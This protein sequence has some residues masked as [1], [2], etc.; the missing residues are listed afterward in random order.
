VEVKRFVTGGNAITDVALGLDGAL[1][2]ASLGEGTVH[3]VAF[4]NPTDLIVTPT[5]FQMIEG[6]T[7]RFC[8]RLPA[9]PSGNV[10]VS[11]TLSA[12]AVSITQG[13]TLTFTPH[14]WQVPQSV[15]VKAAVDPDANPGSGDVSVAANGFATVNVHINVTDTTANAPVLS[16]QSLSIPKGSTRS[17]Q[18]SLPRQ[19]A[20]AVTVVARRT[21]GSAG[22]VVQSGG[23]LV[24]TPANWNVPQTVVIAMARTAPARESLVEV[25]GRGYFRR[26][27]TVL[28]Q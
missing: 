13:A 1:Y 12:G 27:V 9:A 6:G 19:P 15:T 8:V 25:W 22:A 20:Q 3:R 26:G 18:V 14:N 5:T 10:Q 24:F 28:P 4:Q 17:F 21:G 16:A 7:A 11:V 2:Y 23:S